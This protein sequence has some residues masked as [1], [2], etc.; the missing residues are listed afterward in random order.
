MY[1]GRGQLPQK[2]ELRS[3]RRSRS[4]R[5]SR[6]YL[7]GASFARPPRAAA[8]SGPSTERQK[9]RSA[10]SDSTRRSGGTRPR[11]M[12]CR[13]RRGAAAAT[14]IFRRTQRPRRGYSGEP[15]PRRRRGSDV[16]IPRSRARLTPRPRRG[17]VAIKLER[18]APSEY[19]R[20][21]PRRG[22][23]SPPTATPRQKVSELLRRARRGAGTS[24]P[25]PSA[26]RRSSGAATSSSSTRPPRATP[27][28]RSARR[29]VVSA[30]V[31]AS[32]RRRGYD[33]DRPWTGRGDAAAT[34]WIV[35]GLSVDGSRRRR[36]YDVDSP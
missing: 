23:D 11:A 12:H 16:D 9:S 27:T 19:S 10:A 24:A 5:T 31:D 8:T 26:T 4:S 21:T 22:R 35:L 2:I 14:W 28:T 33:V 18:S 30:N 29:A 34:T 13:T 17:V 1:A 32:R 36:G 25:K 3:Q 15:S 20:G 7:R 6:R